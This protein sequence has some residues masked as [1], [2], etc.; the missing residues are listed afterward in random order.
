MAAPGAISG[1]MG[2]MFYPRIRLRRQFSLRSLLV[3]MTW[4]ALVIAICVGQQQACT[5]QR[6]VIE[7]LKATGTMPL[8]KIG[9]RPGAPNRSPP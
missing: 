5:R 4:L 6:A 1:R 9:D 2:D 8:T 7:H 3:G